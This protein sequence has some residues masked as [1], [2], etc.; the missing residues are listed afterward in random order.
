MAG[1][2]ECLEAYR[3]AVETAA[4]LSR[5][6]VE[7]REKRMVERQRRSLHAKVFGPR[8]PKRRRFPFRLRLVLI[9]AFFFWLMLEI[10][11][12]GPPPA[13]VELVEQRGSVL[14][15]GRPLDADVEDLLVLPGRWVRTAAVSEAFLEAG[16]C[17][18]RLGAE[19]ELLLEDARP[20]RMRLGRGNVRIEGSAAFVTVLGLV[21]VE[22][23][24]GVLDLSDAC[25]RLEPE[26]GL[27]T[28]FDRKGERAL[29]LGAATLLTP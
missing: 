12:F 20:V 5:F 26:G 2:R 1:C 21:T 4:H 23:G 28:L 27:W 14:L 19:T 16:D 7:E 18:L 6:T 24:R 3:E 8:E 10:T 13:R 15:D 22:E 29:P 25:L 11:S 9:P 17:R